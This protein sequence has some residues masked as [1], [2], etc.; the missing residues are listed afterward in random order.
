MHATSKA[1]KSLGNPRAYKGF[2]LVDPLALIPLCWAVGCSRPIGFRWLHLHLILEDNPT[3]AK[4]L[5]ISRDT[6]PWAKDDETILKDSFFDTTKRWYRYHNKSGLVWP[7]WWWCYVLAIIDPNGKSLNRHNHQPSRNTSPA[8]FHH[9]GDVAL[10]QLHGGIV[11]VSIFRF[12]DIWMPQKLFASF[13]N[14]YLYWKV[15]VLAMPQK[16]QMP[17][18][19]FTS[20]FSNPPPSEK[21]QQC[22]YTLRSAFVCWFFLEV[23]WQD[24]AKKFQTSSPFVFRLAPLPSDHVRTVPIVSANL[25]VTNWWLPTSKHL[26]VAPTSENTGSTKFLYL[27]DGFSPP[28]W[29][30]FSSN[31]IISP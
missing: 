15:F 6:Y 19:A 21:K 24:F 31:W 28:I 22:L 11:E 14:L 10:I 18:N 16:T 8:G 17:Y 27:V 3:Q 5:E 2:R 1:R 29:R 9:L 25:P 7:W 20:F 30:I 23:E 4:W 12:V 13:C 26:W